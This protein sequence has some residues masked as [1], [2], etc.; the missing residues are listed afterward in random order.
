MR[1]LANYRLI[2]ASAAGL[3]LV[4]LALPV[5]AL[6]TSPEAFFGG[7][8]DLAVNQE[9]LESSLH[10][11]IAC[12]ACH[13]DPRGSV[14][15]T[16]A[17]VG[18]FYARLAGESAAPRYVEFTTPPREACL[19]CHEGDWSHDNERT[20]RIPHPAHLRV[21]SETR[22]CVECHKWTAHQETY[23]AE[24][25][26]MPFSGVCA[27]YGCHV[28]TRKADQCINCHH[29]LREDADEWPAEHAR[30]VHAMGSAACMESC[31]N[32]AECRLCHTTGER[33]VFEGLPTETGMREIERLHI[34]DDWMERHGPVG[35]EDQ[36][37]CMKCHVSDGE[38]RAC[39]AH[40]PTSHDPPETW[41]ARH[42]DVVEDE[43]RCLT[44]HEQPWCQEC[45][46]QFKEMQ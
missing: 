19:A 1:L 5:V 41:L 22:E 37:A 14:A 6:S 44:C 11:G 38:C 15:Y 25:K 26:E 29:A 18:D 34:L 20:I 28:G 32:A 46:D 39:H 16:V 30:V 40:R 8:H 12:G 3:L 36:A 43:R 42:K 17:F 33:P 9:E 35:F 23:I 13:P 27:A 24:H 31:H 7:Y 2:L 45:H 10:A 21:A 4:L